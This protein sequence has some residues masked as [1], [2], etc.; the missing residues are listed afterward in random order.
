MFITKTLE[1][2]SPRDIFVFSSESNQKQRIKG[3]MT[4]GFLQQFSKSRSQV[5]KLCTLCVEAGGRDVVVEEDSVTN[6]GKTLSTE[7]K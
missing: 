2:H 4:Y 5:A 3:K 1:H 6:Y 7:E